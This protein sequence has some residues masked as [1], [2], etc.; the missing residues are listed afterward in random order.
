[1]PYDPKVCLWGKDG[2]VNTSGNKIV[3]DNR[4]HGEVTQEWMIDIP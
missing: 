1:M 4:I 2:D 3:V